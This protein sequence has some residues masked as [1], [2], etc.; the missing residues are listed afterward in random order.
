MQRAA[1]LNKG[2]TMKPDHD[3]PHTLGRGARPDIERQARFFALHQIGCLLAG[4]A[5]WTFI[6]PG[7]IAPSGVGHDV[8][9]I[10]GRKRMGNTEPGV[11]TASHTTRPVQG[12]Y[13]RV[14]II[15]GQ[16]DPAV[17]TGQSRDRARG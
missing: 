12:E 5:N 3:R 9:G 14:G 1:A 7:M 6:G 4:S 2:A 13:I 15:G 17:V 16:H 10:G 8:T 11:G